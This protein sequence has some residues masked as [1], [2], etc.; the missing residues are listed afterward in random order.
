MSTEN[1]KPNG[2]QTAPEDV[3]KSGADA[4]NAVCLSQAD[5]SASAGDGADSV[6]NEKAE[7]DAEDLSLWESLKVLFGASRAFWMVNFVSFGDG[8]TYFGILTLLT[9]FLGTDLGMGDK[10]AGLA[11]ST[12][13]GL[14]TLFVFGGGYISDWLGVRRAILA[15]LLVAV[16]GRGMLALSPNLPELGVYAAWMA[17]IL[18]AMSSG[19]LEPAL[20]SGVKEFTD[21]RTASIGYGILY[22]IMNLGI[23]GANFVSPCIRSDEVFLSLGSW[24]I[25]GLGWGIQGVFGVCAAITLIMLGLCLI[26]FTKKVEERDRYVSPVKSEDGEGEADKSMGFKAKMKKMLS[27]F[28]NMRFVFFIFILLPV[29][30]LFAHQWLTLPTYVERCYAPEVFAKFEWI[31]GLNPLII[32]VF[33]PLVAALTRKV[34][35]I[36]MMLVGTTVSALTTFILVP[37]PN[38][39]MLL[40]YV[41][42]FSI[43]EALWSS[44]FL[45]YVSGLAPVGQVGAYMGLAGLPWFLAKF[46][47]GLYSGF[48]LEKFIPKGGVAHSEQLWLIYALIALITPISLLLARGWLLQNEMHPQK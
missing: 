9:L 25:N 5:A 43:G 41:T 20:Y 30:T 21:P 40:L 37:G 8:I 47:T 45:E 1:D 15:A 26:L 2:E 34:K 3:C 33:V 36:D 11:V 32:V 23:V 35:V 22:A 12:F 16:L 31:S 38:L 28:A 42:L 46:T 18:M 10:L 17:I 6:K 39:S 27:P 14:V 7:K 29:R 19:V 4:E 13:T 24:Q 44:R 48:M